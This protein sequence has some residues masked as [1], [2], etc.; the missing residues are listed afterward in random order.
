MTILFHVGDRRRNDSR[1]PY[2]YEATCYHFDRGSGVIYIYICSR[3]WGGPLLCTG[4]CNV[5]LYSVMELF[6]LREKNRVE[7]VYV[8]KMFEVGA[9]ES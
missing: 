1:S 4:C 9:H 5:V 7:D 3:S 2:N 8:L 6:A